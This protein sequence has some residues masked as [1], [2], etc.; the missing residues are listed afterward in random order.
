MI[1]IM[2]VEETGLLR[3]ALVA[4]LNAESDMRVVAEVDDHREALAAA[5]QHRPDIIIVDIDVAGGD[6]LGLVHQI[7]ERL[8]DHAVVVLTSR[9]TALAV[10]RA[11]RAEVRGF[12]GKDVPPAELVGQLRVIAN[13]QRV[14]DPMAALA[15]LNAAANPLTERERQVILAAARG[16]KSKEIAELLF[17]APGTVRNHL[18]AVMRK[19]G[20]RNRW[21]AIRHSQDAGWI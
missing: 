8:P 3:G 5:D 17:L 1:R 15:A 4:V 6:A 19:T 18:S 14:I 11:L 20:A 7:N 21:E 9:R 13:G 12:L 10:R 16:L 2:I